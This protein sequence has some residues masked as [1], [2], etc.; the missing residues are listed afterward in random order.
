M[1]NKITNYTITVFSLVFLFNSNDNYRIQ[2]YKH[3][4]KPGRCPV[5]PGS[6]KSNVGNDFEPSLLLG[7]WINI[8]DHKALNEKFKCYASKF[9]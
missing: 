3:G 5:K 8:Y 4:I 1:F 2:A 7:P 6:I 9:S